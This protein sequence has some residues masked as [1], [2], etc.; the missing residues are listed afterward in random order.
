MLFIYARIGF[1][2][3]STVLSGVPIVVCAVLMLLYDVQV[4]CYVCPT[5]VLLCVF[6]DV[7]ICFFDVRI[8]FYDARILSYEVPMQFI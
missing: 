1:V 6:Y 3:C 2:D 8:W 5:V 4:C 7:P